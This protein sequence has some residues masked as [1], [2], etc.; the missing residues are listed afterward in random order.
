[1]V[2]DRS[3]PWLVFMGTLTACMTL[4]LVPAAA[5]LKGFGNSG[6]VTVAPLFSVAAGTYATGTPDLT[7]RGKDRLSAPAEALAGLWPPS[8]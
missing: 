5:L 6:V 3:P 7:L 8:G 2:W 4:K 1:M